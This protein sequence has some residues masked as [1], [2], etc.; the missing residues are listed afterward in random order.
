LVCV[1]GERV[2]AA[3]LVDP[4]RLVE[5]RLQLARLP[6]GPIGERAVAPHLARDLGDATLRVVDVAL[7]LARRDRRVGDAAVVEALRVERVLPRL[8]VEPAR[9]TLLELDEAV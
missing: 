1:E 8:D 6:L 3:A 2:E 7:H 9:C 4:E 5:R